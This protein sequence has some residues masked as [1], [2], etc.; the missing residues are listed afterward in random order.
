[1]ESAIFTETAWWSQS[2]LQGQQVGVSHL[3]RVTRVQSAIFSGQQGAFS[4]L[5]RNSRV[6]STNHLYKGGRVQ[7]AIFIVA[8]GT[9]VGHIYTGSR[10]LSAIFT[11]LVGGSKT[12]LQG[13]QGAGGSVSYRSS[14]VQKVVS[15]F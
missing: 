7:S 12:S 11:G 15:L 1:V 8:G 10:E 5:Y 14:M 9:V 13:Q 6:Q 4:N 2:S 3:Y